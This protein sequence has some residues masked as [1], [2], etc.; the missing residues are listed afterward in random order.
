MVPAPGCD[1]SR[2]CRGR[3]GVSGN[4]GE[5]SLMMARGGG[6]GG[7]GPAVLDRQLPGREEAKGA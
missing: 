3:R 2:G 6:E 4:A 1:S 5:S 7:A